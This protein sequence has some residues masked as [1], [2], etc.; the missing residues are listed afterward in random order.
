[1]TESDDDTE[2]SEEDS[3][4]DED[5]EGERNNGGGRCRRWG[6]GLGRALR[7][8]TYSWERPEDKWA[9]TC[10]SR[11]TCGRLP[12]PLRG[13][14]NEGLIHRHSSWATSRARQVSE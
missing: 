6:G 7:V 13:R 12:R 11:G 9:R 1:M 4:E 8:N 5:E 2:D 3:D 10:W 14:C